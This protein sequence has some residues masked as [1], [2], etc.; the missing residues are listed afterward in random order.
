LR[1]DGAALN[2]LLTSGA[3]TRLAGVLIPLVVL[4]LGVAWALVDA[5]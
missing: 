1:R 3:L 5:A 4:W 2:S